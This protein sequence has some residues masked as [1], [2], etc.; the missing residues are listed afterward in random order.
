MDVVYFL[1]SINKVSLIAFFST[2]GVLI[3]EVVLFKKETQ[4]KAKP[5]IPNFQEN[6]NPQLNQAQT[7]N[8]EKSTKITRPN[9][10][11][12]II[13]IILVVLF[14]IAAYI[15]FSQTTKETTN[16]TLTPTPIINFITS[17][18]IKVYNSE[19]QSISEDLLGN[20]QS[21]EEIII[22]VETIPTADIDRARI[23]VNK[24]EWENG[25]I[26]L[27]YS[28]KLKVYYIK[29]MVASDESKLKVEAQLHSS[30]EGW[31]GD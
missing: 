16:S 12:L 13:S 20:I 24:Q 22:G 15:G 25:D 30:S 3:Y 18:G 23:R 27:N 26:T 6:I 9:N 1:T 5:K 2:L 14:G 11:V 4:Q 8:Q 17:K 7:I 10:L 19:F 29:Y 21:G 28:D 31:L